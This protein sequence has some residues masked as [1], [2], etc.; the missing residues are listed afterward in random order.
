[1]RPVSGLERPWIQW[2]FVATGVLVTAI[3]AAEAVA[4][5]RER[6]ALD[7][8]RVAEMNA[9]LDRQQLEIQL[10]HERSSREALAIEVSRLRATPP[11]SAAQLPT[12]TL[13]PLMQRGAVAPAAS[14]DAPAREQVIELRLLLPRD[15]AQ[16]LRDVALAIRGWSS[17]QTFWTRGGL[18][19]SSL[20]G[21]AAVTTLITGDALPPGAYELL[22]T[23]AAGAGQP[24][25][26]A[27]YEVSIAPKH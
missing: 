19:V 23:G 22:L 8:A 21:R 5:R 14:V 6:A 27:R 15:T 2:S 20:D 17:G 9:R 26:V 7:T 10:T 1:M 12:L 13:T 18:A 11:P 25:E 16:G 24:S 3:A 4:I